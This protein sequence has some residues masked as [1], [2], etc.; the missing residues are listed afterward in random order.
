MLNFFLLTELT[1]DDLMLNLFKVTNQNEAGFS[2]LGAVVAMGIISIGVVGFSRMMTNSARVGKSIELK[3]DKNIS[4][5]HLYNNLSCS[6]SLPKKPI[7]FCAGGGRKYIPI[8]NR[9]GFELVGVG[10]RPDDGKKFGEWDIRASC[11][12]GD[13]YV[14]VEAR[15]SY[16][17]NGKAVGIDDPLIGTKKG[18][19]IDLFPKYGLC[20]ELLKKPE[21]PIEKDDII[22]LEY[23]RNKNLK[24]LV[25][26]L[27]SDS[28][29]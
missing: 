7:A 8:V 24:Q 21:S 13:E 2:L 1:G 10:S 15:R 19:W 4:R 22:Y 9:Q 3:A 29:E 23:Y 20:N 5:T 18:Q 17:E 27:P 12:G 26:M 14:T 6:L 16:L 25:V 11:G 28:T